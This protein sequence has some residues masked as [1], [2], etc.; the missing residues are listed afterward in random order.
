[1][2]YTTNMTGPILF[3]QLLISLLGNMGIIEENYDKPQF[4][5]Y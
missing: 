1:M 2:N 4:K 5:S 3:M